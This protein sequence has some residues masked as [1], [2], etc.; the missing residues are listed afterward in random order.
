MFEFY[1]KQ[2]CKMESM[3][4]LSRLLSVQG[5]LASLH[6]PLYIQ[7]NAWFRYSWPFYYFFDFFTTLFYGNGRS[8]N[9]FPNKLFGILW[10]YV[11]GHQTINETLHED[12]TVSSLWNVFLH[13][14]LRNKF[15]RR[16]FSTSWNVRNII[17][18]IFN[19]SWTVVIFTFTWF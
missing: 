6:I 13:Q 14:L 12:L 18:H 11:I 4:Q 15:M 1:K 10:N 2:T 19:Y 17:L 16:Y 7:C 8:C 9:F 3:G 5:N